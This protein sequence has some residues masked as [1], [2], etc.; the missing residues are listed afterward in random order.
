MV[1]AYEIIVSESGSK[2][3]EIATA[4]ATNHI[5]Q[6]AQ[7]YGVSLDVFDVNIYGG[8]DEDYGIGLCVAT[9]SAKPLVSQFI[10]NVTIDDSVETYEE[11]SYEHID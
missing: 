6:L 1:V 2:P 9:E 3:E 4:S 7:T 8:T 10:K 11:V 5:S